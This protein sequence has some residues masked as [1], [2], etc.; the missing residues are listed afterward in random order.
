MAFQGIRAEGSCP[1]EKSLELGQFP[2]RFR[3]LTGGNA[4]PTLWP[5]A[6]PPALLERFNREI[7]VLEIQKIRQEFLPLACHD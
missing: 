5:R 1:R 6:S 7:L 2:S 3:N 4:R